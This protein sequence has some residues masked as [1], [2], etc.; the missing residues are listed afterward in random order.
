MKPALSAW[1]N[2]PMGRSAALLLWWIWLMPM[3]A[4]A[5][6]SNLTL[7][8]LHHR[9]WSGT[10]EENGPGQV[11]AIAQT[12]DGYLW[13]G[14]HYS[15]FRFDGNAF[16]RYATTD[17]K[18]VATVSSLLA[19]PGG[20][21]WVGLRRGGVSL[22]RDGELTD[23]G[24][25]SGFPTG[26]VY[27]LAQDHDGDVWAAANDGLARFDGVRWH[28]VSTGWGFPGDNARAV[29]VD[30]DGTLWAA[31]ENRLF[32]LPRG[33]HRFLDADQP[34]GWVSQ[35]TQT[36]DGTLWIAELHPG[37]V[38]P[39]LFS[40][41]APP[42][43][44]VV[45]AGLAADRDG[46]LWIGT[47]GEGLL[48]LP[49]AGRHL[50]SS[51]G[52]LAAA[53]Q[54]YGHLDGLSADDIEPVF[55]DEAGN[56]WVGTSAGLDRFRHAALVPAHLPGGARN[57]ALAEEASGVLWAGSSNRPVM[58]RSAGRWHTTDV[59]PPINNA[60]SD[61][62]GDVWLGGP[63][64]IWRAHRGVLRRV[65]A[66]PPTTQAEASV[67][68]MARDGDGALWVS[69]NRSGLFRWHGGAWQL[70]PPPTSRPSQT[71]PVSATRDTQGRVWFGYRD[72]LLVMRDGDDVRQ[73]GRQ[74]GLDI[75]NAAAISA[76]RQHLWLAGTHGAALFDGE[77]FHAIAS[78]DPFTG[79]HAIIE[80]PA[81]IAKD[82]QG[83]LP[84]ASASAWGDLWLHTQTG[85]LQIPAGEIARVLEE[86]GHRVRF[87]RF[88]G[89]DDLP[90]DAFRIHPVPTAIR[91][92]DGRLWFATV[93]G[94]VS[95]DPS[96]SQDRSP[97]PEP[98]ITTL[99]ADTSRYPLASPI[100]SEASLSARPRRIAIDYTA[101]DLARPDSVRFRYRLRGYD[102][103][104]H[105]AGNRRQAIYTRLGPGD[106]RFEV[107][108]SSGS[109]VWNPRPASLILHIAPAFYQTWT[110]R[111]LCLLLVTVLLWAGYR[112][113]MRLAAAQLRTRLETRHAERERIARELH[114]TLLQSIQALVL[115]FQAAADKMP[116]DDPARQAMARALDR[117]DEVIEEG[118]DRV[119][120]LRHASAGVGLAECLSRVCL[121]RPGARDLVCQVTTQGNPK[122]LRSRVESEAYWIGHEA[123]CNAFHHADA[124]RI[125]VTLCHAPDGFSLSVSDDGAGIPGHYLTP[126]GRPGHWG[127]PHM[128]ERARQLGGN[129]ELDSQADLGTTVR[130][131]VPAALAYRYHPSRHHPS[132]RRRWRFGRT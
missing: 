63:N 96:R 10:A 33:S 56:V 30:R 97:P 35:I 41:D 69:I 46:N 109:G 24:P 101:I 47:Q 103:R 39:I 54:H 107:E 12:S 55:E 5:L 112:Y 2:V 115:H 58:R 116:I 19:I 43:I 40:G 60:F 86:P 7:Q 85:V 4:L 38:R 27:G 95:V 87:R 3:T 29:F 75:G 129:L 61:A 106:Y 57:V 65:T 48:R 17:G 23:Y 31:S 94:V 126:S 83:D 82:R 52:S 119:M 123:L 34:V 120:S 62:R 132:R 51:S 68:A 93:A 130:L 92:Q 127:L 100:A 122:P 49:D 111:G 59:A 70:T 9:S 81:G 104:W 90:N 21:L 110:F 117:A 74:D 108:A 105:D 131:T 102:T 128:H 124:T 8:Q 44:D 99:T 37:R 77:R 28:T 118:R 20:G 66:L 42:F 64:G 73:W 114:D 98:R 91:G 121:E 78:G 11:G 15:L 80:T 113:R 1:L 26:A 89:D 125:I 50:S 67:R 13:L 16:E 45:S 18:T 53:L 25:G 22:I 79:I 14:T 32:F 88:E 76:T 36:R 71:M 72:D 84:S 6:D